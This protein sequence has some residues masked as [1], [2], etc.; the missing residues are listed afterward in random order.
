[1][2]S[3]S[4][5][6]QSPHFRAAAATSALAVGAR[7]RREGRHAAARRRRRIRATGS[8]CSSTRCA[9][10]LAA[11]FR[12]TLNDAR[13]TATSALEPRA[14]SAGRRRSSSPAEPRTALDVRDV[15]IPQPGR[16]GWAAALRDA[17]SSGEYHAPAAL[18]ASTSHRHVARDRATWAAF[19]AR[20]QPRRLDGAQRR[21]A[22]GCHN[23][24]RAVLASTTTRPRGV[25]RPVADDRPARRHF[26]DLFWTWR[27]RARPVDMLERSTPRAAYNVVPRQAAASRTSAR[28]SSNCGSVFATGEVVGV[29]RRARR[30]GARRAERA[31]AGDRHGARSGPVPR[32]AAPAALRITHA[33]QPVP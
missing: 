11:D 19:G 21:P 7:A 8:A 32:G 29:R 33:D 2:G 12:R 26:V 20:H 6:A 9:T 4:R 22:P 5:A 14:S 17:S 13:A 18:S 23:S 16:R 28:G 3:S 1:M 27:A 10:Q 15:E 30:R 24:Q 31:A 25:R